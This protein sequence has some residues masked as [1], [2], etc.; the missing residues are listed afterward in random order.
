MKVGI[1]LLG[2]ASSGLPIL[3]GLR[4]GYNSPPPWAEDLVELEAGPEAIVPL[5]IL[6][7]TGY[8]GPVI[9]LNLCNFTSTFPR[10]PVVE[11]AEEGGRAER[12]RRAREGWTRRKASL[13]ALTLKDKDRAKKGHS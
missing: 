2:L 13:P 9:P 3:P 4:I 10:G 6:E 12:S 1:L 11:V 8:F 5:D 7:R